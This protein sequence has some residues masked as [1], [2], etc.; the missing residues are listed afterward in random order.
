[1]AVAGRRGRP[2]RLADAAAVALVVLELGEVDDL[3]RDPDLVLAAVAHVAVLDEVREVLAA[4]FADLSEPFE[5]L[6]QSHL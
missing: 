4:L 6:S 2:P 1:V 5:V 3:D